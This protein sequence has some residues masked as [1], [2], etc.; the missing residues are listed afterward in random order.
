MAGKG[1]TPRPVNGPKYR[2]NFDLI[3]PQN[4]A[5]A[6]APVCDILQQ[7]TTDANT[8]STPAHE[9]TDDGDES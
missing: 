9:V 5:C 1:D 3:F 2:E 8:P 4:N 6:P 7:T